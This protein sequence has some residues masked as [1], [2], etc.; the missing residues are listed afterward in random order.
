MERI[1]QALLDSVLTV[2]SEPSQ[3]RLS[4]EEFTELALL[5]AQMA[6]RYPSQDLEQAVEGYTMDFEQLALKYSLPQ[7]QSAL[8]AL[9]I[10]PE[11]KFFPRPDEV[12]EEILIQREHQQNVRAKERA[13][14]HDAERVEYFWAEVLPC[15]METL[16][17]TEE[18]VLARYPSI[19][20][21]KAN[22]A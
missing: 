19:K 2:T 13:R 12:A 22:A 17:E 21:R 7:V 10:H 9:R 11:Q 20:P 5:V 4:D 8:Q 15:A 1:S 14:R 18:Q 6:E 16:G 3:R